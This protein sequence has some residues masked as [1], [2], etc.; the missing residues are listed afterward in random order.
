[1]SYNPHFNQSG[2]GLSEETI[3]LLASIPASAIPYVQ[4]MNQHV[5]N[6]ASPSFT[7]VRTSSL[8]IPDGAF[9][10]TILNTSA[11]LTADRAVWFPD[12]DLD[13]NVPTFQYLSTNSDSQCILMQQPLYSKL[14]WA[15]ELRDADAGDGSNVGSNL[16]F[17]GY[18]DTNVSSIEAVKIN[19]ATG[20]VGLNLPTSM[21]PT[22]G[23]QMKGRCLIYG[24]GS[25]SSDGN[26]DIKKHSD[27]GQGST[28][29]FYRS[30]GTFDTPT[31]I[32]NGN[33]LWSISS[34]V[35]T[36]QYQ[37]S[38]TISATC[39]GL[40]GTDHSSDLAF[41]TTNLNTF[42]ERMNINSAGDTTLYPNS[43]LIIRKYSSDA[44]G[45]VLDLY[46]YR[47]TRATPTTILAND[48]IAGL[49][50]SVYTTGV[51]MSSSIAFSATAVAGANHSS[52]IIF[53]T[54]NVG[55]VAER[56][57]ITADGNVA[58]GGST[59]TARQQLEVL[60]VAVVDG[61]AAVNGSNGSAYGTYLMWN[62]EANTGR[63]YLINQKGLGAGGIVLGSITDANVLTNWLT[64]NSAGDTSLSGQLTIGNIQ[65]VAGGTALYATGNVVIFTSSSRKYKQDIET[66]TDDGF[67]YK[68]RPVSFR[69]KADKL[70]YVGMIAE[71]LAEFDTDKIYVRYNDKGEPD[72]IH[73]D[74]F[75]APLIATVQSLK[76]EINDLKQFA[77]QHVPQLVDKFNHTML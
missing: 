2:I 13:L 62:K 39:T 52:N 56:M 16:L 3:D 12:R 74:R 55:T 63:S 15:I 68:L 23:L 69:A 7:S 37:G 77:R 32:A 18:N 48:T 59:N 1:M 61:T 11:H 4:T 57:R 5:Y 43:G 40:V 14:R 24:E 53:S 38:S 19:R 46:K 35:Y 75:I 54:A 10:N 26:I 44:N 72:G 42:T 51:N 49:Y 67:L 58:I 9:K 34:N 20:Y 76:R 22:Y 21:V 71:E 33:S 6:T 25:G 73:Y 17:R 66:L 29:M 31:S 8:V 36:N 28:L 41:Y 30:K 70:K 47:G 64:I 27:D 60:G 45:A 50:S 65:T